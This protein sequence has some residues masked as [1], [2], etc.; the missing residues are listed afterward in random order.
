[1]NLK[2]NFFGGH[3]VWWC[4]RRVVAGSRETWLPHKTHLSII[5]YQ[6]K[7]QLFCN[8]LTNSYSSKR[9]EKWEFVL[10][11]VEGYCD[12][13]KLCGLHVGLVDVATLVGHHLG[14]T[15][16]PTSNWGTPCER[17]THGGNVRNH[18]VKLWKLLLFLR[19]DLLKIFWSTRKE[20]VLWIRGWRHHRFVKSYY[21]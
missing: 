13:V 2:P 10:L 17:L 11:L 20:I 1:M 12:K 3:P 19:Q 21:S 14:P 16:L 5:A 6:T 18:A 15:P 8:L 4:G 7:L 9:V